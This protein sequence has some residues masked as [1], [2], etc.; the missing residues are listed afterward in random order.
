[1]LQYFIVIFL[2]HK[3]QYIAKNNAYYAHWMDHLGL[4]IKKKNHNINDYKFSI[5]VFSA[6]TQ[7]YKNLTKVNL[8]RNVAIL[9]C[10]VLL[11]VLT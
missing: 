4:L 1:M 3:G 6:A 8:L 11:L 7:V 5:N 10:V 2:L 9:L